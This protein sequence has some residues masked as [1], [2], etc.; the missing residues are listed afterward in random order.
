MMRWSGALFL[1]L[2][3]TLAHAALA[4]DGTAS[5]SYSSGT[6][7]ASGTLTTTSTNDVIVAV[8]YAEGSAI[9]AARSTSS[10]SATGLTFSK[11]ASKVD[12][13]S[14]NEVSSWYAIASSTFSGA[15]TCHFNG[16]LDDGGVVVFGVSGANTTTPWDTS[17]SLPAL[18][19]GASTTPSVTGVSTSNANDMILG[20]VGA[21]SGLLN[22]TSTMTAGSGFT[23]TI[24]KANPG[25]TLQQAE[26]KIVS[27]TQ[28]SVTINWGSA[29]NS[30]D[31]W[32]MIGDAIQAAG[33]GG[34]PTCPQ[35]LALMGVGC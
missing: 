10:V 20:L 18:S 13:T 32:S 6:S 30:S 2:W 11:R 19:T 21:G 4:I 1:T 9:S 35:T 33:G 23:S 15:I 5:A 7:V 17:A 8:C 22:G 25:G 26:D 24:A 28:S 14:D 29:L 27:A 31:D 34:G 16:T 12:A 3:A